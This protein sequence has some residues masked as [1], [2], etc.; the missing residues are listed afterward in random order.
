MAII[1]CM[2]TK[3]KVMKENNNSK[4]HRSNLHIFR[5]YDNGELCR[6]VD[7][8]RNLQRELGDLW[9]Y[10][11]LTPNHNFTI[12]DCKKNEVYDF[13]EIYGC[14]VEHNYYKISK[15][16][17]YLCYDDCIKCRNHLK[18]VGELNE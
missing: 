18:F 1:S 3:E 5:V 17:P 11:H 8:C 16:Q 10:N 4:R 9:V 12:K 2:W 14:D 7:G 6:Q 15:K 13:D